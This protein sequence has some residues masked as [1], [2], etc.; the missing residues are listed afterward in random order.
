MKTKAI[1]LFLAIM[2]ILPATSNAQGGLLRRAINRQLE[3][4]IDSAVDKS[5]QDQSDKNKSDSTSG[6]DNS[7][8]ATGLRTVRR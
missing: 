2:V 7:T 5:V 8:K 3:H 1:F 6:K 4:K